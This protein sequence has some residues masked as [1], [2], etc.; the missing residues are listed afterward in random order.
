MARIVPDLLIGR[1]AELAE[2]TEFCLADDDVLPRYLWWRAD[3]WAGKSALMSWFVLH[4]PVGVRVVSFFITSRFASNSDRTAFLEIVQQQLAE[5]TGRPE[6]QPLSEATSQSRF[7]QLLHEAAE[8]CSRAGERLVLLVDGLDE[9]TGIGEGTHGH[10]IAAL[11]PSNPPPGVRVVVAGRPNPP[12]PSDVPAHHALR[13]PDIVRR[14]A[15]SD[16]ARVIRDIVM[17]ELDHLLEDTGIA[18][19]ILCLVTAARGGLSAEDL[20]ELTSAPLRT[21][22]KVLSRPSGRTFTGRTGRWRP[23]TDRRLFVLAHEELQ[24]HAEKYLGARTLASV[25]ERLHRWCDSYSGRG[26]PADTPEYLLRGYYRLLASTEDLRR[27]TACAA[28]LDRADRMLDLSGGDAQALADIAAIQDLWCQQAEPDLTAAL[29]VAITRQ[30][31]VQRN[32]NVSRALL[33]AWVLLGNPNRAEALAHSVAPPGDRAETLISLANVMAE[34][35][36]VERARGLA[37]QAQTIAETIPDSDSRAAVLIQLMLAVLEIDGVDRA[38]EIAHSIDRPD[39]RASAL[40]ALAGV[41]AD[42]DLDRARGLAHQAGTVARTILDFGGQAAE[43]TSLAGTLADAGEYGRARELAEQGGSIVSRLPLAYDRASALVALAAVMAKAG[44]HDRAL[45]FVEQAETIA[46]D[47]PRPGERAQVLA[48]VATVL[49][50]VGDIARAE[51][52]AQMI[53]EPDEQAF[54]LTSL[55]LAIVKAGDPGRAEAIIRTISVPKD[56]SWA[57]VLLVDALLKIPNI[58]CAEGL[59][60]TITESHD[61]AEAF[62]ALAEAILESGDIDRACDVVEQTWISLSNITSPRARALRMESLVEV[63]ANAGDHE[64]AESRARSIAIPE[65]RTAALGALASILAEFGD[66]DRARGLAEQAEAAARTIPDR[67]DQVA[68]LWALVEVVLDLEDSD[69]AEEVARTVPAPEVLGPVLIL[70]AKRLAYSEGRDRARR[71]LR[72]AE[73]LARAITSTDDQAFGWASLVEAVAAVGD[74]DHAE[75]IAHSITDPDV[76]GWALRE[77]VFALAEDDQISC[78][79]AIAG[80]MADPEDRVAALSFL[81]K[82]M[83]R[84]GELD[85]ARELLAEAETIARATAANLFGHRE[86]ALKATAAAA[87]ALG[88]FDHAEAIARSIN[89]ADLQGRSLSELIDALVGD[90]QVDRAEVIAGSA[91]VPEVRVAVLSSLAAAM[92]RTGEVARAR[93]LLSEAETVARS[94]PELRG[95][96]R[97]LLAAAEAAAVVG[98]LDRAEVV[99]RSITDPYLQGLAWRSLAE[100]TAAGTQPPDSRGRLLAQALVRCDYWEVLGPIARVA[101]Q[102]VIANAHRIP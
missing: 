54:A 13:S 33:R 12:I 63:L 86:S 39:A 15:A 60:R 92:A 7:G 55:A 31:I 48:S 40:T 98:D 27:M 72:V 1:E 11:L 94:A 35:D 21:V 49:V 97:A 18:N 2:L 95:R 68:A 59:A 61:R 45:E 19:E 89:D 84:V 51:A 28:D 24:I 34:T 56:Q 62:T 79:E 38:E 76:L 66:I 101:K 43:L 20:A 14:L 44:E 37:T 70:L 81:V 32:S 65:E 77:L 58:D 17:R 29:A 41:M 57:L 50:G 78:A 23:E 22:E 90:G 80:S 5:I 69:R 47:M 93:E 25:R 87:A 75:A 82:A 4:P 6:L 71:L 46:A 52:M 26:W 9:D 88:D 100:A 8:V 73:G 74:F 96:E 42:R 30:K 10:S 102:A 16:K 85:R 67:S 99:A 3:A 64:R 91:T 83:A 36:D 53:N